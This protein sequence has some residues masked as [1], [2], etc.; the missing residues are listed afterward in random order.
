L[1]WWHKPVTPALG[2]QRQEDLEFEAS[3][4][5]IGVSTSKKKKRTT[6]KKYQNKKPVAHAYNPNYSGGRD[7]ED[8]SLKPAWA[9]SS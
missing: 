4:G 9:N 7:Q 8:H 6:K 2:R 3:L 1:T 5:C